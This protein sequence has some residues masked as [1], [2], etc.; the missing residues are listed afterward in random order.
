M[1]GA[2]WDRLGRDLALISGPLAVTAGAYGLWGISDR[3]LFIGPFDRATFGWLFVIPVWLAAPIVAAFLWRQAPGDRAGWLALAYT[4][5]V[6]AVAGAL[7]WQSAVGQSCETAPIRSATDWV[8]PS[9]VIGAVV[10]ASLGLSSVAATAA[11]HDGRPW[12]VVI[13]VA[14]GIELLMAII[15]LLVVTSIVMTGGCQRPG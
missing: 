6:G 15:A 4:L 11:A 9:L 12:P 3:L 5:I 1:I 7:F 8:V 14:V 10:G 13:V 2:R